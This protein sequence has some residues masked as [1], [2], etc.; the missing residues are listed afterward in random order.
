ME[1]SKALSPSCI[2]VSQDN[3]ILRLDITGVLS[4]KHI[5]FW[6]VVMAAQLS[7]FTSL[8]CTLKNGLED[9]NF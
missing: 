3:G 6:R 5:K 4:Q 7:K 8:H 1:F 2:D 9:G